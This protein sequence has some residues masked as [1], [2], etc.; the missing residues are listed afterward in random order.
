MPGSPLRRA[1][2]AARREAR[3]YRSAPIIRADVWRALPDTEKVQ[4][5]ARCNLDDMLALSSIPWAEADLHER[6][7]KVAIF[8]A[9]L[10]AGFQASRDRDRQAGLAQLLETVDTALRMRSQS[11][12]SNGLSESPSGP[13]DD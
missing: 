12:T 2:E 4:I 7:H 11:L 6:N 9:M 8:L 3:D 1:R 5:I 10:K 13:S